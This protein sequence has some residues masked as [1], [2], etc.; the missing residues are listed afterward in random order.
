MPEL[1]GLHGR[2]VATPGG[3]DALVDLLLDA[4]GGLA[5]M[6]GCLLYVISRDPDDRDSVWITEV[7]T[8]RAAH[9]ASLENGRVRETIRRAR[10]LIAAMSDSKELVPVGGKGI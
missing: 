2:F 3:G 5:D 1:Y 8:N 6:E 4:S 7:W 10:P 9:D